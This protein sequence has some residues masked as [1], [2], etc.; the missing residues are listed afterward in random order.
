MRTMM[1]RRC[2][3]VMSYGNFR[4]INQDSERPKLQIGMLWECPSCF[5]YSSA[6]YSAWEIVNRCLS[7]ICSQPTEFTL[8]PE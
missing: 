3:T 7:M 2:N 5:V 6:C 1:N 8:D 4:F